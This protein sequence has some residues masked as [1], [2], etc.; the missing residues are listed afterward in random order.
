MIVKY[1]TFITSGFLSH[2]GNLNTDRDGKVIV[3]KPKTKA[4]K[5]IHWCD[6]VCSRKMFEINFDA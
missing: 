3:S 6:Y 4:Q 5:L 2:I 1:F